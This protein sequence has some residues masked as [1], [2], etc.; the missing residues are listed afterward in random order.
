MQLVNPCRPFW[1][2]V[3]KGRAGLTR[4]ACWKLPEAHKGRVRPA[5]PLGRVRALW[6]EGREVT[7][8]PEVT[9]CAG[10]R[11]PAATRRLE[12]GSRTQP[13]FGP[14]HSPR[15]WHCLPRAGAG[16]V[17]WRAEPVGW[18]RS[19]GLWLDSRGCTGRRPR[20]VPV[21]GQ[22]N[23]RLRASVGLLLWFPCF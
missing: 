6:V 7:P 18:G 15:P 22:A 9:A 21:S 12:H 16:P 5:C 4:R 11:A 3:L 14:H 19:Q 23:T 17:G 8:V 13:Q 2:L 1:G 10:R 20:R